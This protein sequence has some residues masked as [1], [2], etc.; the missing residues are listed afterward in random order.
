[1]IDRVSGGLDDPTAPAIGILDRIDPTTNEVAEQVEGVIGA[2]LTVGEGAVWVGSPI[3]DQL[4]RVDLRTLEVTRIA[5]GPTDDELPFQP[6]VTPGAVWTPNHHAGTVA[7]VDTRSQTLRASVRWGDAGPGGPRHLA[8]D[9]REI[10]LAAARASELIRI[11]ARSNQI[12]GRANLAPS[13]TCGGITLDADFLWVASG[14]DPGFSCG[15][16]AS[17]LSRLDR[18]TGEVDSLSFPNVPLDV[19]SVDGVVWVLMG[20]VSGSLRADALVRIDPTTMRLTGSLPVD[21]SPDPE[22]PLVAGFGSIWIRLDGEV[23]RL[24][25]A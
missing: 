16:G 18:A 8:T 24:R 6:V 13:G 15:E 20:H 25:A 21:G 2:A 14:W 19:V 22:D 3:L 17:A 4:L 23:L 9:G 5:T 1:V 10:W 11:D 7:R 12:T